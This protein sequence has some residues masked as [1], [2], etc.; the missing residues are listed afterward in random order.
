MLVSVIIPSAG[1]RSEFL[2]RAI[3]S[4]LI[5]DSVIHTEII[6]VL[7]GKEGMVFDTK[8]AFQ[9]PSVKYYKIEQGNVSKARNY[10]L[11]LA[12]GE[13]IRF[14]DDDDYLYPDIASQQYIELYQSDVDLST[15]AG[16]IEDNNI[17]YQVIEPI[18]IDDYCAA[19]LSAHCP[20]LT[21]ATVYKNKIIKNIK[22][23]EDSYIAEDEEWMRALS[24][25][26]API[27][28]YN[29][30]IV[31]VWFQHQCLRLSFSLGHPLYYKNR[32]ESINKLLNHLFC[33]GGLTMQRKEYAAQGLWSAIHGGFYF[34]P[35]YWTKIAFYARKL[36]PHSMPDEPFFNKLPCWIHPLVIEWLMLPKRWL[37][38][39]VRLLKQKLGYN[40][41]IRKI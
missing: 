2:K 35:I 9:H 26:K 22:W 24:Y 20:A 19:T 39:Q 37:N 11:S 18:E 6:V 40:S 1:R 28:L 41:S 36:D 4:A 16:A 17:R 13:L 10:G 7:N 8:K 14:L 32:A 25:P 12:N 15:Y 31:G 38:H 29:K 27:W 30:K 3:Q 23:N 5:D 33:I 34:E 21:F